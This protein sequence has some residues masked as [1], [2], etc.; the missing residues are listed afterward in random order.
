MAGM[1]TGTNHSLPH[2]GRM[3]GQTFAGKARREL[4][5]ELAE[6]PRRTPSFKTSWGNPFSSNSRPLE[7]HPSADFN[8]R[9]R[10]RATG[11]RQAAPRSPLQVRPS[12]PPACSTWFD[13]PSA[14]FRAWWTNDRNSEE[15]H[16][17]HHIRPAT[18]AKT[19]GLTES[20]CLRLAPCRFAG[21][22][23]AR[24][25]R[26][27][28]ATTSRLDGTGEEHA[29]IS[30]RSTSAAS[31]DYAGF[32]HQPARH[33]TDP[34]TRT[35]RGTPTASYR[36]GFG[37]HGHRRRQ[38]IEAQDAKLRVRFATSAGVTILT[39]MNKCDRTHGETDSP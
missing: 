16:V 6:V 5:D 15:A 25:Q 19:D 33:A 3:E 7:I 23:T 37:C 29:A 36:R 22:V 26:E 8:A 2:A 27:Q 24:K 39:F 11:R 21:S 12:S 13:Q 1:P 35:F 38:G 28:R 10:I 32:R 4:C 14:T 18:R 31:F 34:A 17:R 9:H 30:I 20:S